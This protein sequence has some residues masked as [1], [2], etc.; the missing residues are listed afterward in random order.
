[1]SKR[2]PAP[3]NDFHGSL[4]DLRVIAALG[5]EANNGRH[6][7]MHQLLVHVARNYTHADRVIKNLE[8]KWN[9][10]LVNR[11]TL[12]LTPDGERACQFA[13]RIIQLHDQGPFAR[14]RET[15]RI[16][17][18]NRVM[19]TFLAPKVKAFLGGLP[20]GKTNRVDVDLDLIEST[21]ENLL[22]ALMNDDVDCA[23]FGAVNDVIPAGL[24]R[25]LISDHHAT[26]MIAAKDG[27]EA[28]DRKLRDDNYQVRIPE[29]SK[30]N[31]CLIHSDLKGA[32]AHLPPPEDGYS[33]IVVENYASVVAV[34]KSQ[35]AVGLVIDLG[36]DEDVLRFDI[37]PED[38][39]SPR[40][41]A[42]WT[43]D[44]ELSPI[45]QRFM[46]VVLGRPLDT[47]DTAEAAV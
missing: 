34:V 26:V 29:L 8:E 22:T 44:R 16:G 20:R 35:I 1:M 6:P 5:R 42:I 10:T 37:H 17:T 36:L 12:K 9:R 13:Q 21:R 4:A 33:R 28:F 46:S 47:T 31:V 27:Y 7:S 3:S 25:Y 18:S 23:I 14:R 2:A 19:T 41:V 11:K 32:L 38:G 43:R 40:N 30:V 45:T 39:V 15:L 24:R